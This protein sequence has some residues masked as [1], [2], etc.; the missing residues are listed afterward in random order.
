MNRG[1]HF[2]NRRPETQDELDWQRA[3]TA[4]PLYFQWENG[5]VKQVC[6]AVDDPVWVVNFK[7]GIL[8]AMQSSAE[9]TT[10]GVQEVGSIFVE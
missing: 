10:T 1:V 7:K 5:I 8:S 2:D 3:V 6:P 9:Q 4:H